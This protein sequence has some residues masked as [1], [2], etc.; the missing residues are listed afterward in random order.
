MYYSTFVLQVFFVFMLGFTWI[1]IV[2]YLTLFFACATGIYI[3]VFSTTIFVISVT[4]FW[5]IAATQEFNILDNW[6]FW[7]FWTIAATQEFNILFY[8]VDIGYE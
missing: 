1:S 8:C 6:T 4:T 2:Q 3:G 7:T 5:T